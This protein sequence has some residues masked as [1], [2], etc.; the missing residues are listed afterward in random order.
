MHIRLG[1]SRGLYT[2]DTNNTLILDTVPYHNRTH[3]IMSTTA[4]CTSS[5]IGLRK[6]SILMLHAKYL[7]SSTE[8]SWIT[9]GV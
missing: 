2:L 1:W 7:D 9:C 4:L 3:R 6:S 5:I 8:L